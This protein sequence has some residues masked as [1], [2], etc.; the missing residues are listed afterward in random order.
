MSDTMRVDYTDSVGVLHVILLHK[1][2]PKSI[3]GDLNFNNTNFNF[4]SGNYAS[5]VEDISD[6]MVSLSGYEDSAAM[7][8]FVELGE[9][10]DE[11]YEITVTDLNSEYCGVYIIK[12]ITYTPIGLDVFE[13]SIS[14]KFVREYVVG[15][16]ILCLPICWQYDYIFWSV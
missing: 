14:L 16:C 11:G 12:N 9:V 5:Y 2:H 10:A 8:K 1:P 13:Y 6:E 4:R 7:Q 15:S 3:D